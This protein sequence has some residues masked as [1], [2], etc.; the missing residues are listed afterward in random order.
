MMIAQSKK[1]GVKSGV[2]R[3]GKEDFGGIKG[4]G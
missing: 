2:N 4:G 3:V 1:G